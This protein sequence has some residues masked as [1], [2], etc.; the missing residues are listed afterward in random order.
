MRFIEEWWQIFEANYRWSDYVKYISGWIPILA[1]FAPIAGHLI[2]FNDKVSESLILNV[3]ANENAQLFFFN[4][5]QRL[6][7]LCF[8]LI[9]LGAS[10]LLY[11]WKRPYQFKHGTSEID[12]IRTGFEMYT[13]PDYRR[14]NKQIESED[15]YTTY[16]KYHTD[17]WEGFF[18]AARN[19]G[20]GTDKVQHDGDWERAKSKYG[21]L[22]RNILHESFARFDRQGRSWLSICIVLSTFG[23]FLILLPSLDLFWVVF[24]STFSLGS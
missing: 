3:P 11:F 24:M 5:A 8:G 20:A 6:G 4:D 15:C 13:L 23:Y 21:N 1:F 12:Y 7:L 14:L 10:N 2:L 16:G 19:T 17:E 18:N 9:F 22:L